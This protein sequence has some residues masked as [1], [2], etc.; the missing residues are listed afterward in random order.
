MHN[1]EDY[2]KMWA[3]TL[4]WSEMFLIT[5]YASEEE[6]QK[7][8][9]KRGENTAQQIKLVSPCSVGLRQHSYD[10]AMFETSLL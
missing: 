10:E 7:W 5:M 1:R 9:E 8:E 3:A 6:K 4:R 2:R